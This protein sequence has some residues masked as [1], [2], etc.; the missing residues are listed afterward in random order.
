MTY[1][2]CTK[3]KIHHYENCGTCFGFGVFDRKNEFDK[4]VPVAAYEAYYEG[5]ID[6]CIPCPE[7]R[8]TRNGIPVMENQL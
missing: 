3:C 5:F 6:G 4:Y 1:K 8:S 2:I 7:C